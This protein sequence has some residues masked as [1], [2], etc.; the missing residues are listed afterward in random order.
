MIWLVSFHDPISL[1]AFISIV[2]NKLLK[3]SEESPNN[4]HLILICDNEESIIQ[5]LRSRFE[6]IYLNC[7]DSRH[8]WASEPVVPFQ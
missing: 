6:L 4:S 3:V 7:I 8:S 1:P 2:L 5:T